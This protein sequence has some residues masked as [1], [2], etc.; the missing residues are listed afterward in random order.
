MAY[1]EYRWFRNAWRPCWAALAVVIWIQWGPS[2]EARASCGDYLRV[3]ELSA[4]AD[5]AGMGHSQL[6]RS[7]A[8]QRATWPPCQGPDCERQAPVPPLSPP[9]PG[10]TRVDD[11]ALSGV[12]SGC[13]WDLVNGVCVERAARASAGHPLRLKRPPR[14]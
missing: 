12:P 14:D 10:P 2:P 9:A 5:P 1:L 11:S 6:P 8:P 13:A 3:R 7:A 4:G